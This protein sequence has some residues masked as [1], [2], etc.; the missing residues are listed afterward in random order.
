MLKK[1]RYVL[2]FMI[3]FLLGVSMVLWADSNFCPIK[4]AGDEAFGDL[5]Q[6]RVLNTGKVYSIPRDQ[7]LVEMATAT[8]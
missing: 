6:N 4:T 7:V 3:V 2:V 1:M 5:P 8:W